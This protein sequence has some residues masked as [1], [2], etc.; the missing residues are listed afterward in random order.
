MTFDAGAYL[1]AI[2]EMPDEEINLARAALAI[3]A[4]AQP[5]VHLDRYLNHLE[6]LKVLTAEFHAGLLQSGAQDDVSTRHNALLS[7]LGVELGYNGDQKTYDDLQNASLIRVIERRKG[8][9]IALCILYM[10]AA[11]AQGWPIDGLNLPGHFVCRLEKDGER[12]I[13]D[14]FHNGKIMGAPDLRQL[15]KQAAGPGAELSASYFTPSPNRDILIRL[16][17]NIKFRQIDVEDYE[18]AYQ[19]VEIMRRI[20][21]R[22]YRLLL[23]AGVLSARTE[24]PR[25]AIEFLEGYIQKA[26]QDHDRHEASVL[27]QELRGRLN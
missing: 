25:A 22:E 23:D 10:H 18:G 12:L 20:A 2:A 5:G 7:V 19:T 14:A 21:P 9:P 27:L 26:P 6:K 17:N 3:A 4:V 24:R 11:R 13:F 8:L 1:D 15:I 16:Q